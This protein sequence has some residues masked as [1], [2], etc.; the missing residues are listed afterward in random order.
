M[1]AIIKTDQCIELLKEVLF[2]LSPFLFDARINDELKAILKDATNKGEAIRQYYLDKSGRE[3]F[4]TDEDALKHVFDKELL[5]KRLTRSKALMCY[6]ICPM[7]L[8][9]GDFTNR[10]R[11][12]DFMR[13]NNLWTGEPYSDIVLDALQIGVITAKD[14]EHEFME[15]C[16]DIDSIPKYLQ[17]TRVK[18]KDVLSRIPDKD[19]YSFDNLLFNQND[20]EYSRRVQPLVEMGVITHKEAEDILVSVS[21]IIR[22]I[23]WA[24]NKIAEMYK[25]LEK[26]A[27]P[28]TN[29]QEATR[30]I[31][32]THF[33][34][35]LSED[36]IGTIHAGL[37]DKKIIN[38]E[39]PESHIEYVLNG[40]E[41]PDTF[42][43]ISWLKSQ[44][45]LAYFINKICSQAHANNLWAITRQ[46]FRVKEREPNV[47][48]MKNG[49]SKTTGGWIKNPKNSD[50]IDEILE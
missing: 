19:Y 22:D 46:A 3:I 25:E 2:S 40:G 41:R 47:N 30:S 42:K 33:S 8:V 7:M 4:T 48:A 1:K 12:L 34:L 5:L 36:K 26:M 32:E 21:M 50:L 43:A 6:V 29:G 27:L 49:V 28:S 17:V 45:L 24:V 39:T 18:F 37:I 16:P 35:G 38:S 44:S 13:R 14:L 10:E 23:N 31:T 20:N 9:E 15:M 11:V